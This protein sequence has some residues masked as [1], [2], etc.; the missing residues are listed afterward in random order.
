MWLCT[1]ERLAL[2]NLFEQMSRGEVPD[3]LAVL[4]ALNEVPELVTRDDRPA[5]P[6]Q[7]LTVCE[8]NGRCNCGD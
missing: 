3:F 6:A 4:S 8:L 7:P 5:E 2:N 1:M